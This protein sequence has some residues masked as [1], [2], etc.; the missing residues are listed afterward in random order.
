MEKNLNNI[1]HLYNQTTMD[2]TSCQNMTTIHPPPSFGDR[3]TRTT[4]AGVEWRTSLS[5][6]RRDRVPALD[7]SGGL[8]ITSLW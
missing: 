8:Y 2:I 6:Q 4:A 1:T 5:P 7:A 3:D